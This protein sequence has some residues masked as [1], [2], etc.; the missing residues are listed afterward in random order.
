MQAQAILTPAT[1]RSGNKYET[2]QLD[3]T[4]KGFFLVVVVFKTF[5]VV[6]RCDARVNQVVFSG[7]MSF[8]PLHTLHREHI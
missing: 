6:S 2:V 7:L 5:L 4:R 8:C 1:L 3:W